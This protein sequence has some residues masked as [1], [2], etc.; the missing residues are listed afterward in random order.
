M[1]KVRRDRGLNLVY[2]LLHVIP[3]FI[4]HIITI[5]MEKDACRVVWKKMPFYAIIP[6]LFLYY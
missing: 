4:I 3:F 5:F 1:A 2:S 6:N